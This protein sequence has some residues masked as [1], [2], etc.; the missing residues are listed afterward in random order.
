[1]SLKSYIARIRESRFDPHLNLRSTNELLNEL[2]QYRSQLSFGNEIDLVEPDFF[3]VI[4]VHR[5]VSSLKA[6]TINVNFFYMCIDNIV[7]LLQE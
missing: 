7:F 3:H 4:H 5:F 6:K 1:M 2:S